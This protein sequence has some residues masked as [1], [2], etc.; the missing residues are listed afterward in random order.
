M[1]NTSLGYKNVT[2]FIM[3]DA[4][5]VQ[6][7]SQLQARVLKPLMLMLK[8]QIILPNKERKLNFKTNE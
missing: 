1:N 3:L 2:M 6:R 8:G 7:I 4:K 5:Y